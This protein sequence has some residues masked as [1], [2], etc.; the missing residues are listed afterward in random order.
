MSHFQT[1]EITD[2]PLESVIIPLLNITETGSVFFLNDYAV[3]FKT[4]FTE[5]VNN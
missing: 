5:G 3:C 1:T 2:V 4:L